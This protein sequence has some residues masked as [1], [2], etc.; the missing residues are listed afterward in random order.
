[1]ELPV[2]IP[3][4]CMQVV[5]W[6][7]SRNAAIPLEPHS[8][9]TS[10]P[11]KMRLSIIASMSHIAWYQ[12]SRLRTEVINT[13][14]GSS[15]VCHLSCDSTPIVVVTKALDKCWYVFRE[16][17]RIDGWQFHSVEGVVFHK[18][19]ECHVG[20]HESLPCFKGGWE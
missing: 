5:R 17:A 11:V 7:N 12:L 10:K 19:V 8:Y 6:Q 1:M 2:D 9:T 14:R 4:R 20:Q 13:L 3:L 18:R 15:V 16:R